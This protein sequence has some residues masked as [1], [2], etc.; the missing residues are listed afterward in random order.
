MNPIK[1]QYRINTLN[2]ENSNLKRLNYKLNK[3]LTV[4]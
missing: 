4:L 3:E 2:R 1:Y